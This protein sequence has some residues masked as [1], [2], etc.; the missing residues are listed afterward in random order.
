[1]FLLENHLAQQIV[2][3]T[4][5][6]I[7]NNIN[8]MNQAGIIIGSGDD[9]RIGEKH[10]GAMLA[11]QRGCTVEIDQ[12]TSRNLKGA[13]PGIN[14]V[15][16]IQDQIIGVVG[17]TGDPEECRNY[18]NLVKM[19]AEMIVEQA[20]LTEQLQWDR[21]HR[22]E[23]ISSWINNNQS[24]SELL[25]WAKRLDID[26][27][28]PR[29]AVII[30]FR[31]SEQPMSLQDMRKVVELLEYPKRD[32]LVAVLS[33]NEMVVLKPATFKHGKW[34][35]RDESKRIDLLL[36]RLKENNIKH[37]DI[38]LG[39]FFEGHEAIALSYQSARLTLQ[40][41]ST[42]HKQQHKH[43]YDQLRLPVL[44]HPLKNSWQGQQLCD[45][46]KRLQ[47]AD[48]NGQ[49][50]KTL[51]TLFEYEQSQVQCAQAL[52]IHR[53][54]LRYRIKRIHEISKVDPEQFSGLME[55]YIGYLLE[56][57]IEP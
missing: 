49:L 6:I 3:R 30:R 39:H 7:G 45:A 31:D 22:E 42:K 2:D 34:N 46:F 11:L 43:L 19:S 24:P 4:M 47:Q 57:D 12:Q 38:A 16:K 29:V 10:D 27:S 32:N 9:K 37:L 35:S 17:I 55:L 25:D 52:F 8:V 40:A 13:L 54:T 53:N 33:M 21:R 1:M 26:M 18:A 20:S 23:F 50:V 15:L 44:L 48:N 36:T 5:A 56:S 51:I 14:L 41:G 28:A